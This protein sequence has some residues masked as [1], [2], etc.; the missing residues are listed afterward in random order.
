MANEFKIKNGAITPTLVANGGVS[1]TGV[2][3]GTV[4]VTGGVGISENLFVGGNLTVNGTTTTINSTVTTIDDPVLTLGGDTAPSSDDS[5][6]RGIEFRWHNGSAAKLGFFGFDR[7]TQKWTFIPD[8][9]NTSEVFGG[10]KGTLDVNIEW[11]DVLGKPP[12]SATDTTYI[13]SSEPG[14]DAYSAKL[15]LADSTLVQQNIVL[16]VGADDATYGLAISETGSTITLKHANTSSVS[17][18]TASPRT[19]V[20][21]LTFDTYGHV[22]GYTTGSETEVNTNTTYDIKAVTTTGG[23]FLRLT[24]SDASTDDVKFAGGSNVTVEY[25]DDN[26]I[27]FS[28]SAA[29][30]VSDDT[31]TNSTYYPVMSTGTSGTLTTSYVSSTKLNFNPSNGTLLV[32]DL[33]TVSDQNLKENIKTIQSPMD[34]LEKVRGVGFNWKETGNKSYGVVAQELETVLPELVTTNDQ[35]EKSV[36]Y[37]PLMAFLIET[38]KQQQA[39]IDEL[40][41]KL[42]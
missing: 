21:A 11:A 41:A 27:T 2:S 24:G 39:Q 29:L 31:T 38:V 17:N 40:T 30:T 32:V 26:T 7:S 10:T 33:N 20:T 16:A 23:A 9:T 36:N 12:G 1:S 5:K 37:I 35:G 25:T 8:A 13:F 3:S 19:Y 28:A 42:R 14:D 15:R 18:L 4:V 34:V 6:D 22:T